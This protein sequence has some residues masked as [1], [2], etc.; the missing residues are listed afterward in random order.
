MKTTVP[1]NRCCHSLK[2]NK[3]KK[4]DKIETLK[5]IQYLGMDSPNHNKTNEVGQKRCE[6]IFKTKETMT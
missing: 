2:N 4:G 3:K 5:N 6:Y 1:L